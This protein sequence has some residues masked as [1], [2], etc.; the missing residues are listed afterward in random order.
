MHN[1][2]LLVAYNSDNAEMSKKIKSKQQSC[3]YGNVS[4]EEAWKFV[5]LNPKITLTIKLEVSDW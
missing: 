2:G 3:K 1:A 5:T 4:E